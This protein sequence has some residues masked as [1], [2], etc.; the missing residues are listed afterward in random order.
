VSPAPPKD[1]M[2]DGVQPDEILNLTH[3]LLADDVVRKW[4]M[5][6]VRRGRGD[7]WAMRN[8]RLDIVNAGVL[9][10]PGLNGTDRGIATEMTKGT[11]ALNCDSSPIAAA[12]VIDV[13]KEL[14]QR[15]AW[16][17]LTDF[18]IVLVY[19]PRGIPCSRTLSDGSKEEMP[20]RRRRGQ[21][22][23]QLDT[24][25]FRDNAAIGPIWYQARG[26]SCPMDL[27]SELDEICAHVR[28]RSRTLVPADKAYE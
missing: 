22:T 24:G 1:M 16:A 7:A 25:E 17:H 8:M 15:L 20:L 19:R 13:P 6:D 26:W 5:A 14:Q 18:V 28:L 11:V 21:L 27:S 9:G 10:P 2:D 23:W 3:G 12:G 4:I